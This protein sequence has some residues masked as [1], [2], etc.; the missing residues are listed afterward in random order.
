MGERLGRISGLHGL[1]FTYSGGFRMFGANEPF[2]SAADLI[3]KR[4]RVNK[5]PVNGDFVSTIGGEPQAIS[6]HGYDLV[7]GNIDVAETT[8]IRFLGKHVLKT[9]HN[10]FLTTIVVN[11]QLWQSLDAKLQDAFR[12]AAIETAR[13]E[14]QWSIED[15]EEFERNCKLNGVTITEISEEEKQHLRRLSQPVYDKWE[16]YFMPGL[17]KEIKNVH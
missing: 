15:A 3:G 7:E 6:H 12:E 13:L 10:M 1:S 14:R 8:Y 16:P 9:E 11:D 2:E 5:N 4:V 17:I